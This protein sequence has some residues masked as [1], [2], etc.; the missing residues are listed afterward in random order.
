[1]PCLLWSLHQ[2]HQA[3]PK[4]SVTPPTQV[5][6]ID[7]AASEESVNIPKGSFHILPLHTH[8]HTHTHMTLC[9]LP[10]VLFSVCSQTCASRQGLCPVFLCH[11]VSCVLDSGNTEVKTQ[12]LF[13]KSPMSSFPSV[14]IF[15]SSEYP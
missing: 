6:H 12:H 11:P 1:L 4:N 5:M 10:S 2:E 14:V 3:R 13:L 8:T 7:P 9:I 15:L